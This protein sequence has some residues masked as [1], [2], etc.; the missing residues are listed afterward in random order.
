MM[1]TLR[2]IHI[3]LGV[4]WGGAAFVTAGFLLPSAKAAGPGAG[5]MMRE[6][7]GVRRLPIVIMVAA[8]LT[9]L[10]GLGMYWHDNSVSNG[11]FAKSRQGMTLGIGAA[12][13]IIA[14]IIGMIF[15]APT[16]N[17]LTRLTATI[18]GAGAPPS[19][20]QAKE[21]AALQTRMALASRAATGLVG[22]T[23]IT[24]AIARYV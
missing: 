8:I 23:I 1:L 21:L 6:L 14:V 13:A 5:P 10:S 22:I 2:F 9:V 15:V 17:K 16:G 4:F 20:E 3:V 11:A 12:L 19:A 7:I 18:A 24:M